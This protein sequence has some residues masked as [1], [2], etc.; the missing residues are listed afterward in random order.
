MCRRGGDAELVVFGVRHDLPG[1]PTDLAV[2][3]VA[4]L[5]V[6]APVLDV[7]AEVVAA[8]SVIGPESRMGP[9]VQTRYA[10]LLRENVNELILC[11]WPFPD[12][13]AR[14]APGKIL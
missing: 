3:E 13:G 5:D 12:P 7:R 6:S 8:V 2:V 14:R 1:E 4:A 9:A 11:R 10:A